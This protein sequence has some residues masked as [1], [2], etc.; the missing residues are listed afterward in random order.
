M[1]LKVSELISI[2][3]NCFPRR[4]SCFSYL[5]S[6]IRAKNSRKRANMGALVKRT[7]HQYLIQLQLNPLRTKAITAGVLSGFSD[8][9]AQKLSGFERIQLR[10]LLLKVLFGFA[11]GGPFG[12]FMHKLLDAIFKGKKD[13]KTVAKKVLLEQLT[14]N[15]WNNMLFLLYYGLI[16]EGRPWFQVKNKVKKDY[17][18]VQLTSWTSAVLADSWVDKS[19]IYAAAISCG[20]P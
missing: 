19:P 10:R 11:Y 12:H 7:W 16:V 13:R 2:Y 6:F 5:T 14:S 8:V 9:V 3:V 4:L 15:P 17:P 1:L 18:S 20:V